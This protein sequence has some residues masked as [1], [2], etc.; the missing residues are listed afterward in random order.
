[1]DHKEERVYPENPKKNASRISLMT[2]Y[3][4][5]NIFK[6]GLKRPIT[7]SDVYE[8]LS[9][10]ESEKISETFSRLWARELKKKEPSVLRMIYGAYGTG[11]LFVGLTFSLLETLNRCA[12]PL[13]L[14]ALLTYFIDPEVKKDM[15]YIYATGIVVCSLIPV[16]TFHP[17]IYY[18]MEHGMKI[19]IGCSRLIYDKVNR[20]WPRHLTLLSKQILISRYFG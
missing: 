12:Q 13:F 18:I 19:R 14:G 10:H 1:M 16:L 2:F 17:F 20:H 5:R 6:I 15:A 9:C 3:W 4:I 8:P 7:A 11:I